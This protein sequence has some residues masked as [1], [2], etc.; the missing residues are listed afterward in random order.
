MRWLD[1][2]RKRAA[3]KRYRAGYDWAAGALLRGTAEHEILDN[4]FDT[5]EFEAGGHAAMN[6]FACLKAILIPKRKS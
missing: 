3:A 2:M 4:P 1:N 5:N 6:D